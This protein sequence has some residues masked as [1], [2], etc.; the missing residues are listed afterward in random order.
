M[1]EGILKKIFGD[2][3]QKDL[4]LSPVIDETNAV[5]DQLQGLTDD[6]LRDKTTEFKAI[7]ADACKEIREQKKD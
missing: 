6:Q 1:L 3:T 4:K 5:F 2:K 7:I